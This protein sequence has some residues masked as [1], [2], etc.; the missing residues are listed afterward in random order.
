[1]KLFKSNKFLLAIQ[2]VFLLLTSLINV[3][4]NILNYGV[5]VFG[6][7][8]LLFSI[9]SFAIVLDLGLSTSLIRYIS[10]F[11]SKNEK[12]KTLELWSTFFILIIVLGFLLFLTIFIFGSIVFSYHNLFI[13]LNTEDALYL[14]LIMG[15]NFY[16]QFQKILPKAVLEGNDD[17][18]LSSKIEIFQ[19]I[20]VT[21]F[22]SFSYIYS[23]KLY[24]L[25]LGYC[26]SSTITLLIYY[27]YSWKKYN[28]K[29]LL[30][31]LNFTLIKS[32]LSFGY[33]LQ[34][35][36]IAGA[37]IDPF[38]KF[39][40][41]YFINIHSVTYYEIARKF[42]L[43]IAGL[44]NNMFRPIL[45][46]SSKLLTKEDIYDFINVEG[47]ALMRFSVFYSAIMYGIGT[48]FISLII[49]YFYQ[50][51]EAILFFCILLLPEIINNYG[52]T[53]YISLI[54]LAQTKFIMKIQLINIMFVPIALFTSLFFFQNINGLYF[55]FIEIMVVNLFIIKKAKIIFNFKIVD[56]K[57]Q[58]NIYKMFVLIFFNLLL[59]LSIQFQIINYFILL[60]IFALLLSLIFI[61]DIKMYKEKF[62]R[63][64]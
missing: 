52:Y 36:N 35:G 62:M 45:T 58:T 5:E 56:L 46:K 23:Q 9:W 50:T 31:N 8:I 59:S 20:S 49:K 15:L 2:Y 1:M 22:V 24:F 40:V 33:P 57:K 64:I 17:F 10:N 53:F 14:F 44:F 21:F 12:N 7:W 48:L 55:Y 32:I 26:I 4:I 41:G 63:M 25:A 47:F 42:I 38:I 61:S 3:K 13:I 16:I 6:I 54:G 29:I 18:V 39:L 43:A 30:K 28:F 37:L 34:L 51:E 27:Y 19:N 60:I 11:N